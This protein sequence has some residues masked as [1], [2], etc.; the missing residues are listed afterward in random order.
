MQNKNYLSTWIW[1]LTW[2]PL[3]TTILC[4]V[5]R[6]DVHEGGF[7]ATDEISAPSP[8]EF[9]QQMVLQGVFP[10]KAVY[11]TNSAYMILSVYSQ[12][13]GTCFSFS[14]ALFLF[15]CEILPFF[16]VQAGL[17]QQHFSSVS[18][19]FAIIFPQQLQILKLWH[20]TALRTL[21]PASILC[22]ITCNPIHS[23]LLL[24]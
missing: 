7:I 13:V 12:H 19:S 21:I 3:V 4:S 5:T 20:Q 6:L 11:I 9:R 10:K 17:I 15:N 16:G 24:P 1:M 8:S 14:V 18:P 22:N 2:E 23:E